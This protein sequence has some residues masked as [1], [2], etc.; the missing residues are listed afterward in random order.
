MSYL[1][2]LGGAALWNL[3][4]VN[5]AKV[6]FAQWSARSG[7]TVEAA[8]WAPFRV[9]AFLFASRSQVKL[10]VTRR[11]GD[12]P[13]ETGTALIGSF[14]LGLLSDVVKYQPD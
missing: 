9:R 3:R 7:Y 5:V 1:A 11:R 14:W 8:R 12:G 4:R 10:S 2:L 13:L 6:R